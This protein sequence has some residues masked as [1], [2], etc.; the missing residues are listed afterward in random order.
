MKRNTIRFE[1]LLK[2]VSKEEFIDYFFR[3]SRKE[4]EKHFNIG[5]TVYSKFKNFYH[6]K[7]PEE[8]IY[9]IRKST[10]L[11]KYGYENPFND[12]EN[13]KNAYIKKDG[14]LENHYKKSVDTAR[15]NALKKGKI[16]FT[17]D[18]DGW[19]KYKKTCLEKYGSE[20]YFQ[21]SSAI[22]KIKQTKH[23]K[24][25]DSHYHNIEQMKQTNKER[26]GVEYN[27]ASNDPKING[28]GTFHKHLREDEKFRQDVIDKR[29]STCM[30]LYGEDYYLNQVQLMLNRVSKNA[31]SSVNNAF[32]T[33]L[34]EHGIEFEREIRVEN[35]FYDFK[36][37]NYLIEINPSATH[38][39]TWGLFNNP[40]ECDYHRKKTLNALKNNYKCVHVFDW[41]NVDYIVYHITHNNVELLDTGKPVRHIYDMKKHDLVNKENENTVIIYDD[42]FAMTI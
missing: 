1:Q 32:A 28:R 23:E 4:T 29:A 38:N 21:S 30:E 7:K 8:L 36:I 13:I 25:G 17:R 22:E 42:G 26:Y 3:H 20:Y 33:Y 39:S 35:Y 16:P 18:A 41:T 37:N 10:N 34:I 12:V 6:I 2:S 31:V 24:Y 19:E 14:T 27:F 11:K 40:K 9:E 15:K 5:S